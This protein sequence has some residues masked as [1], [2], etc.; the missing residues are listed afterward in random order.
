MTTIRVL[1]ADDHPLITQGLANELKPFGIKEVEAVTDG[2]EVVRRFRSLRP[3]VLV[4]DLRIGAVRG[5]DVAR[6]LLAANAGARIVFY[7][8]FDQDHIVREAYRLGGKG[9]VPKSADPSVLAEAIK[10]VHGGGTFFMP[11]I[12][13]RLALM[14]VRGEESPQAKLS[15]RELNVF[16]MMARGLTNAE[17]AD[18][19]GLS[20]K[21]IGLVTQSVK[22]A[23]GVARPA[24]ITRLALKHQLI[25]E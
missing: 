21:T 13:E 16:K 10:C 17:I 5:L 1:V 18:E 15:E 23:L 20:S 2:T 24:D 22:E 3:D 8:Q 7:S 12:A 25:D 4:L 19:L 9:F 11:D 14:S 6:E